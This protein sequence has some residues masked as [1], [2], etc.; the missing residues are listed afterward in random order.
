MPK[1]LFWSDL[2]DEHWRGFDRPDLT[3]QVDGVLIAGN[4]NTMGPHLD[5]PAKAAR[6]YGCPILLI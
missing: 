3:T 4:T 6:K 1:F 5:I 2:H